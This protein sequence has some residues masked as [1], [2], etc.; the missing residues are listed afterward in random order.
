MKV[1]KSF[2]LDTSNI[3]QDGEVRNFSI[4]ADS[5][6]VFSLEILNEDGYYYNFSTRA[7]GSAKKGINNKSIKSGVYKN[8]IKFPKV[9]DADHYDIRLWA[10][11][12]Y[13]T[14]HARYI[15]VRRGDGS[16]DLNATTGSTSNLLLK[17]LHQYMDV[18]VTLEMNAFGNLGGSWGTITNSSMTITG[19]Q[20]SESNTKVSF[21]ITGTVANDAGVQVL[22]QPTIND[23]YATVNRQYG[24][25]VE[26]DGEDLY[27]YS[28]VL[29]TTVNGATSS[30]NR[31]VFDAT[32]SALGLVVG[33]AISI[34]GVTTDKS[35]TITHLDPDGDNGSEVQLSE[36]L[37]ISDE[38]IVTFYYK[39]YHKWNIHSSS[40]LHGFLPGMKIVGSSGV[41][42]SLTL[43][44]YQRTV[45]T[46]TTVYD[47]VSADVDIDPDLV[48]EEEEII[49]GEK[50]VV[51]STITGYS[52]AVDSFGFK[53]TYT[54]G[55]ITALLGTITH[56]QAQY[57]ALANA[58]FKV[59]AYGREHIRS[60][61]YCD[62][63]FS[64]LKVELTELT[65]TTTG[66]V[67]SSTTVGVSDRSGFINNRT[68][69]KAIGIDPSGD[70]PLVTAG[71]GNDGSGNLTIDAAQTLENGQ[72]ITLLGTGSVVTLTGDIQIKQF[73]RNNTTIYFDAQRFLYVA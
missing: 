45:T 1:I 37:S 70:Y 12:I 20:T 35:V 27:E 36:S 17:K 67:S 53:P 50:R 44:D 59:A 52:K 66:T 57:N 40:S 69:I 2:N 56:D 31:L 54:D 15:E 58:T 6:A 55:V 48:E 38:A 23:I 47:D 71:G 5:G 42:P 61:T 9:G 29:T 26:I 13:N 60:L 34:S 14:K 63:I 51:V 22:K 30:S 10:H 18:T 16:L 41:T 19:K 46:S 73:P 72:T 7:F 3:S 24:T 4:V 39:G 32:N 33:D 25:A 68:R 49:E 11:D 21:S 28:R 8:S 64:N 65:T 62:A 43:Q